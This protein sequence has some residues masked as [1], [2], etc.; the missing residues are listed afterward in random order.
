MRFKNRRGQNEEKW[1]KNAFY[2]LE[3]CIFFIALL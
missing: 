3:K 1:K 2:N